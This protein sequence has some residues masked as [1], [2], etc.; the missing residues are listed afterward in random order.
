MAKLC[1]DGYKCAHRR[2]V[3]VQDLVVLGHGDAEDDGGYVLEAVNPLLPLRPLASHV[4][5]P[6]KT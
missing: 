4:K 6:R 1:F 2:L 5:Q 3:F